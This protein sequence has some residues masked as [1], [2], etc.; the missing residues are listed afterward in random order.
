V[1]TLRHGALN[2]TAE[3]ER[4]LKIIEKHVHRLNAIIE[5]LL[6]LSR[7]EQEI[8]NEESI[9]RLEYNSPV[10]RVIQEAILV[11]R[12]KAEKKRIQIEMNCDDG[13]S[14]NIDPRT[15]E[16]AFVNLLDN[17]VKYS[18]ERKK[19][20]VEADLSDSEIAIRFQDFGVGIPRRHLP[21]IFERFYR[22]DT[23]RSRKLGG[24]GLGLSIVKHIV[25]SHGGPV[26]V[27]ST[28]GRG[29]LFTIRLPELRAHLI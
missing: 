18:E 6:Q 28:P 17:A 24:T 10:K 14:A 23:A 5:D 22:V 20:I 12:P 21:R 29:T 27:E 1:E 3:A 4:F 11:C 25:Q 7:L 16:Q 15:M 8:K 19:I 13:L 26:E 2:N 9:L